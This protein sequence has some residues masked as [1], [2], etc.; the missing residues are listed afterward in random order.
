ME[1]VQGRTY[2]GLR[3]DAKIAST[4]HPAAT[5]SSYEKYVRDIRRRMD[6]AE[7]LWR[8]VDGG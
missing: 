7:F 4:W 6:K 8:H 5:S 2:V 1:E 3:T